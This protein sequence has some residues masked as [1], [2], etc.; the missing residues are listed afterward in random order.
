MYTPSIRLLKNSL[1]RL[2]IVTAIQHDNQVKNGTGPH[3]KQGDKQHEKIREFFDLKASELT[4]ADQGEWE[5]WF[6]IPYLPNPHSHP[7]FEVFFT[8]RWKD[9]L[10]TS[11]SNFLSTMFQQIPLPKILA[12]NV[13]HNEQ[14]A[15]LTENRVLK[16]ERAKLVAELKAAREEV[17]YMIKHEGF[18]MHQSFFWA[19]RKII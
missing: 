19:I 11:L 1:Y 3:S 10:A 8:Q 6:S 9:T 13:A 7:T 2:Y 4:Q 16:A 17:I 12:F 18:I 15:R 5:A 14:K